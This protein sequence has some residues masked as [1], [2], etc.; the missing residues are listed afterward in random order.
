MTDELSKYIDVKAWKRTQDKFSKLIGLPVYTIDSI[1]NE[2]VTTEFPFFCQMI[3]SKIGEKCIQCRKKYFEKV[4]NQNNKIIV[5]YCHAGLMNIIVPVVIKGKQMGAV[6]CGAMLRKEQDN[7]FICR[8]LEKETGIKSLELF[9]QMKKIKLQ[10]VPEIEKYATLIYLLSQTIP[11]I[12]HEK[13]E[14]DKRTQELSTL[15]KLNNILNSSLDT[16]KIMNSVTE[17]IEGFPEIKECSMIITKKN[18]R[19]GRQETQKTLYEVEKT[20]LEEIT[21]T[22][23][24]AIINNFKLDIRFAKLDIPH[25]SMI[26]FPLKGKDQTLGALNLYFDNTDQMTDDEFKFYSI[27]ADQITMGI[28]NA[29]Q[30]EQIKRMAVTD[31]LTGLY[32]RRYFMKILTLEI[33]RAKR[34]NKPFSVML[35]DVDDFSNYNNTNGH[36]A[37]DTLLRKLAMIFKQSVRNVDT[38]GRYGGEEFI[39]ILPESDDAQAFEVAERI[40]QVVETTQFEGKDQTSKMTISVGLFNCKDMTLTEEQ[41][42]KKA[43]DALYRAKNSGKNR[44]EKETAQANI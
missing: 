43:D 11:E 19:Y 32:N 31:K 26:S 3:K 39:I 21:K 29:Q 37:G 38:I 27:T 8:R 4:K 34:N 35:I 24:R 40:R 25:N 6:I 10:N 30:H 1:G 17:Q 23:K 44:V 7:V 36:L 42:L 33:N 20:I 16:D 13:H 15:N 2:A 12:V 22:Q 9:D 28:I 14:S 5:Y 41:I 18:K